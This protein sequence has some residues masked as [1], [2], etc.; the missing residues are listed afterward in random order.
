MNTAWGVELANLQK[1][2][3]QLSI[4]C[5]TA[6]SDLLS[7]KMKNFDEKKTASEIGIIQTNMQ[8]VQEGFTAYQKQLE[9]VMPLILEQPKNIT[10]DLDKFMEAAK[11]ILQLI[12]TYANFRT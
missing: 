11:S 1:S 10:K 9:T 7:E 5:R 8:L 4:K 2:G 6:M 12:T 3:T